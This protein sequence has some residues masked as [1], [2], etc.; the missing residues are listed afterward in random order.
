MIIRS[1]LQII[2]GFDHNEL[3]SHASLELIFS[4][5]EHSSVVECAKTCNYTYKIIVWV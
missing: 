5:L 1:L 4:S 2:S 3:N